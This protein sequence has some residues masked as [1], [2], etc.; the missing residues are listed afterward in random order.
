MHLLSIFKYLLLLIPLV[1]HAQFSGEWQREGPGPIT[2]G[3][4]QNI[5]DNEVIGAINALAPHP[6]DADILYVGAVNGGIWR[7]NNATSGSPNW[8]PQLDEQASLSIFDIQFDLSDNSSNTLIA[9]IGRTSSLA[10]LGGQRLGVY[11]TINGGSDWTLLNGGG[12]LIGAEIRGVAARGSVLMA[13]SESGTAGVFR[14]TDTGLTW[15]RISATDDSISAAGLPGGAYYDLVADPV[16]LSRFYTVVKGAFGSVLGGVY[17]SDDSGAS[18]TRVS[19]TSINDAINGITAGGREM[20]MDIGVADNLFLALIESSVVINVFFTT[21]GGTS[22]SAMDLPFVEGIGLHILPQG[23]IHTSL[24]VDRTNPNIV[25]MGG[26]TNPGGNNIGANAGSTGRLM[27]GDASQPSGSQWVHLTNDNNLGPAGGGTASNSAPHPDSRRM[28]V[29]ADGDVIESD[30]GGVYL[31]TSPLSDTGDWF[32]LNGDIQVTEF[33]NGSYDQVSQIAFAGAQDNGTSAQTSTANTSWSHFLGGDG[34]VTAVDNLSFPNLSVRYASAQ[35]LGAFRRI[36]VNPDNTVA[37]TTGIPLA[38]INGSP[39]IDPRFYTPLSLNRV[40]PLR[41]IL[42]ADNGVYESLDQGDTIDLIGPG[43]VVAQVNGDAIA[44]GAQDNEEIL[45]VGT[46]TSQMFIRTAA[47]PAPLVES[48]SYPGTS[49]VTDVVTKLSDSA[50]A[51]A[52]DAFGVFMTTDTGATWSNITNNLS[53]L[54]PGAIHSI[55]YIDVEFQAGIVVGTQSG[56]F[57][58][59]ES[60]NFATWADAGEGLPNAPIYAVEHIAGQDMLVVHAVGRGTWSLAPTQEV[61]LITGFED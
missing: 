58:A 7:T 3:P 55:A 25:Y 42:G 26:D 61:T 53:S 57:I 43:L 5:P 16:N 11:H 9:G 17:R 41:L 10:R 35:N 13:V 47:P 59:Y 52:T 38:P 36:Q 21:N 44:Y 46:Q 37:S 60:D 14:S 15:T 20:E 8:T 24:T 32:S 51:F 2:G 27:R 31:R 22:W 28:V 40:N 23:V 45:Y 39:P 48:V 54:N 12:T 29:N 1:S 50:T 33:H 56:F 34:A 19:D 18:W 30:D 6:T 49:G 4:V